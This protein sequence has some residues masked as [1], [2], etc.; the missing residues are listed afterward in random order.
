MTVRNENTRGYSHISSYRLCRPK[1]YTFQPPQSLNGCHFTA[2]LKEVPERVPFSSESPLSG[3]HFSNNF[4]SK[5]PKGYQ[6]QR[7]LIP[8]PWR[9][10]NLGGTPRPVMCQYKYPPVRIPRIRPYKGGARGLS[11]PLT[12]QFLDARVLSVEGP[13]NS[14]SSVHPFVTHLSRNWLISFFWYFAWS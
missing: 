11:I 7:N 2:F 13:M 12:A 8:S 3:Y 6:F 9:S 1:G 4:A 5:S 10:W 14:L